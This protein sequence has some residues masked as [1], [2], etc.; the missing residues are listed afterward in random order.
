MNRSLINHP[1]PT[2]PAK[3]AKRPLE[4]D[5]GSSRP[6]APK[7]GAAAQQNDTKRRR[8]EDESLMDIP[9]PTQAPRADPHRPTMSGAPIRQSN[10]GKKPSIFN[11]GGYAP[12]PQPPHV[13]QQQQMQA[14]PQ[15]PPRIAHPAT[16]A[17]YANGAKIPFADAPNPPAHNTKTPA[18]AYN[19]K[20]TLALVKS[21]PHY[22]PGDAIHLPEIPTDSEDE[23]SS[24]EAG[25]SFP[26]PDWATPGHLTDQLIRQEGMDGDAVFGP[27]APLKMEEIF[28]KGNKERLKRMRERTSSA[29]WAVSGDGLTVEEVRADRAMRERM[30]VEGGWRYGS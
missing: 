19:S 3:P 25:G 5:T 18:S 12:A 21:S 10:L 26:V 13:N 7:Y 1:L 15:P 29:N 2:N 30:R 16:M 6:Q 20:P 9:M 17:Q 11:H 22:T 14:F 4:E 27:I 28:A 24:D 23:D 8:T